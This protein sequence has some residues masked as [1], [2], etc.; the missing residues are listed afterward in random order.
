MYKLFLKRAF[1]IALSAL[2]IVISA[3]P[4]LLIAVAIKVDDRGSVLFSQRR[5]G[6]NR[7]GRVTY[8]TIYKFRSM[9]MSAPRDVPT[10]LLEN[11]GLYV[12]RVGRF[13]RKFGLDELPQLYQVLC[14]KLSL[15]GPRPALWSQED[16]YAERE[17]YGAN[18]VKPGITGWAQVNGRD[19]LTIGEKARLDG[20][21]AQALRAGDRHGFAMDCKCLLKTIGCLLRPDDSV[22]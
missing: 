18:D 7:N 4:M 11:P 16:L 10:H 22:T 14:G 15:V 13:L 9:K 19:R 6:Q 8:F 1:D 2:A 21:Y 3:I 17:R 12:T 20:A 5:I